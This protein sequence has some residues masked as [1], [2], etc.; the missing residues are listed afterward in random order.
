M[1]TKNPEQKGKAK[2]APSLSTVVESGEAHAVAGLAVCPFCGVKAEE[3]ARPHWIHIMHLHDCFIALLAQRDMYIPR[4][5]WLAAWNTRVV[6]G[7][8]AWQPIGAGL[9]KAGVPVLAFFRYA[10]T[11][12]GRVVRAMYAPSL[13]LTEEDWGDF[14][15]GA[16]Y[17]EATDATYWPEGW[18]ER[19]EYEET[20]WRLSEDVT[21]WMPLPAHPITQAEGGSPS[22]DVPESLA[23]ETESVSSAESMR[24]AEVSQGEETENL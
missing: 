9:P 13:T 5:E 16:D 24:T 2:T 3:S 18:Y 20:N 4:D 6:S 15:S 17:D 7:L 14:Q 11:G 8:P 12:K 19:N 1:K 22:Q 23:P 10:S 21:H